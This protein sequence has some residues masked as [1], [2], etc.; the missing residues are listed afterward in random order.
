MIEPVVQEKSR[1]AAQK[2]PVMLSA[3]FGPMLSLQGSDDLQK[4]ERSYE[5]PTR[6]CAGG[7]SVGTNPRS[8][9]A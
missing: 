4:A 9:Q 6:Y 5:P 8:R 3:R 2:T 1:N 7:V